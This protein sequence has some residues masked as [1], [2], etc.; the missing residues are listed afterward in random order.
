MKRNFDDYKRWYL[1]A[2]KSNLILSAGVQE[3]VAEQALVNYRLAGK[4]D[5]CPDIAYHDSPSKI[6]KEIRKRYSL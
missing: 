1:S 3:D 5:E 6:A 4:I 2:V